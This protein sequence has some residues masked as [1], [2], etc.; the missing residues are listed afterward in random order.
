[1]EVVVS[2]KY[3]VV[4]PKEIRRRLK[5]KSGQRFQI[6]VKGGIITL[7]PDYPLKELRGLFKGIQSKDIREEG[8]RV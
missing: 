8:E 1:M 7:V 4:I 2:P 6:I 5:L 3:Q